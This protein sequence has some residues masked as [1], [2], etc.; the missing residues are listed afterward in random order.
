MFLNQGSIVIIEDKTDGIKTI[1]RPQEFY[2]PGTGPP[3]FE[4]PGPATE[5]ICFR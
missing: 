3:D 4:I 1:P 5:T 2:R